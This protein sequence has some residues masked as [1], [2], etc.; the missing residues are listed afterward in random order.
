M[1]LFSCCEHSEMKNS[2][3]SLREIGFPPRAQPRVA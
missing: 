2:F 3:M 1:I